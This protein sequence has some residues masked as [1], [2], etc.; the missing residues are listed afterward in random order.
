MTA[1][2]ALIGI[3]YASGHSQ[4]VMEQ[5]FFME[6]SA[7]DGMS[8][9]KEIIGANETLGVGAVP[10]CSQATT[11]WNGTLDH[12]ESHLHEGRTQQSRALP[13]DWLSSL[14]PTLS[15]KDLLASINA[16]LQRL[17]FRCRGM[18]SFA[19]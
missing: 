4:L 2:M 13:C 16:G 17:R 11:Y 14:T 1:A 8:C 3:G 5:T 18:N 6:T 15:R 10:T 19:G 7:C 9:R 12:G